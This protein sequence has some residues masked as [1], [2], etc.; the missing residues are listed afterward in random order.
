LIIDKILELFQKK[1]VKDSMF[2]GVAM[3]IRVLGAIMQNIILLK[4]VGVGELGVFVQA[5]TW[6]ILLSMISTI[7]LLRSVVKF[8]SEYNEKPEIQSSIFT[9]GLLIIIPSALVFSALLYFAS[10]LNIEYLSTGM[11]PFLVVFAPSLF[12]Q[13]LNH[14]FDS[15]L[16]GVR[17]MKMYSINSVLRWVP[18]IVFLI[19]F[20]TLNLDLIL[21]AKTIFITE[22]VISFVSF[23]YLFFK[24]D[25]KFTKLDLIFWIKKQ[26][27][28]SNKN[29]L[30][31]ILN[32]TGLRMDTLLIGFLQGDVVV[33]IYSFSAALGRGIELVTG[34]VKINFEPIVSFLWSTN[35]VE[36]LKTNLFQIRKF[37]T[38][39]LGFLTLAIALMFPLVLWYSE[40]DQAYLV[41]HIAVFYLLLASSAVVSYFSWSFSILT[42]SGDAMEF[43]KAKFF[44][45][46]FQVTLI[47]LAG[48]FL[49]II[50]ISVAFICVSFFK[51][52]IF[53]YFTFKNL[54]ISLI[55]FNRSSE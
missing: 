30:A 13:S 18:R 40:V 48:Y 10:G 27:V 51:V 45:F 19:I 24:L 38:Y 54:K 39:I 17:R 52:Y 46:L 28:F 35:Q 15:V 2:T 42:M 29:F 12:F 34:V 43:L 32:E 1:F 37:N 7:G 36:K 20:S 44:I 5:F 3:F 31:S 4:I 23:S 6:Y 47:F 55:N 25:L 33:G 53:D 14:F 21:Y 11:Q 50:W 16:T 49:N 26:F 9:S 8:I 22:I 41:E